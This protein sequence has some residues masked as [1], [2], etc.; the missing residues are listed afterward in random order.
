[1]SGFVSTFVC[2]YDG[3]AL[4]GVVVGGM[5]SDTAGAVG[6]GIVAITVVGG[7]A[8]ATGVGGAIVITAGVLLNHNGGKLYCLIMRVKR[9]A[10]ALHIPRTL[11]LF[12]L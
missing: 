3:V 6:G 11:F 5:L 7:V 4:V 10:H 9:H 8:A 2:G 1:M 12:V